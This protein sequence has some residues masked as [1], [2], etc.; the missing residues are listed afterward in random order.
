MLVK[1]SCREVAGVYQ[2]TVKALGKGGVRVRETLSEVKPQDVGAAIE[3][4]MD[5]CRERLGERQ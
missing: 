4:L 3:D 5:A 2:V 1:I